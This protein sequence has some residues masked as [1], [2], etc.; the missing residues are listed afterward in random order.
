MLVK[1]LCND[2]S[3][4]VVFALNSDSAPSRDDFGDSFMVIGTLWVLMFVM[5]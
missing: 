3:K 1:C 5:L 2:E 4:N